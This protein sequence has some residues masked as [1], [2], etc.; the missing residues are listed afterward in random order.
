[1]MSPAWVAIAKTGKLELTRRG[2][3]NDDTQEWSISAAG[4]SN[5]VN[6]GEEGVR[7]LVRHQL[8]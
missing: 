3:K 5:D 6:A 7:A 4:S 1:M 8:D 2:T